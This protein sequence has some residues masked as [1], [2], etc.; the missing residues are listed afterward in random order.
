MS[1][2]DSELDGPAPG[3]FAGEEDA[4]TPLRPPVD[5]LA[6]YQGAL[7]EALARLR[8]RGAGGSVEARA[9][10]VHIRGLRL[11]LQMVRSVSM[12]G[13]RSPGPQL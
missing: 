11:G 2:S 5:L 13:V 8:R 4:S 6:Y 3:P 12:H 1:Y 7:N 9:L 10:S